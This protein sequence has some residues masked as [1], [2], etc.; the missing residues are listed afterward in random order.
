VAAHG[1]VVF[2]AGAPR[3]GLHEKFAISAADG[4]HFLWSVRIEFAVEPLDE[5]DR[6]RFRQF[7]LRSHKVELTLHAHMSSCFDL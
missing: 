7:F 1:Y 4:Q 6:C 3:T 5:F 2:G